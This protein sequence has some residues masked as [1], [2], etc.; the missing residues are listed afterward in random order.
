M[1]HLL[2]LICL[3]LTSCSNQDYLS[4]NDVPTA[5]RSPDTPEH[6]QIEIAALKADNQNAL[7]LLAKNAPSSLKNKKIS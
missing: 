4:L 5:V 2:F 7:K 3:I 6:I 1:P